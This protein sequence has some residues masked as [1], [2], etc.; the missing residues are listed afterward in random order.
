MKSPVTDRQIHWLGYAGLIPFI[1]LA[2]LLWLVRA[3][4][5]PFVA[6]AL[7]GWGA[8]VVSFLG[9]IH[10]GIGFRLAAS[11][12]QAPRIHFIWGTV[13]AGLAWIAVMM[14]AYA[15]LPLLGLILIACYL[16]DRHTWP[17]A[18][19]GPWLPM[20]LQL[21]VVSTLSCLFG[22]GGT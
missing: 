22:A 18:G 14:P 12:F 8:V 6:L 3:D 11:G 10:W 19:L 16:V 15:G 1:V 21:T 4:L 2:L 5:H 20:R 13:P 9:G 17:E 7:A